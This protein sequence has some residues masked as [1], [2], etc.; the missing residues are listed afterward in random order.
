MDDS[1]IYLGFRRYTSMGQ[2]HACNSKLH[3][4]PTLVFDALYGRLVNQSQATPRMK[5]QW[6]D[7]PADIETLKR[8]GNWKWQGELADE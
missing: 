7:N 4:Q 2:F 5:Q 6:Q 8:G 1:T 3:T